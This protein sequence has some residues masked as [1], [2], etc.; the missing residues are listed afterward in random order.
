MT[1]SGGSPEHQARAEAKPRNQRSGMNSRLALVIGFLAALVL[2]GGAY[3]WFYKRYYVTTDN[4][5]V[6]ADSVR[7]SARI[8]GTV[9]AVH[10]L[11][12]QPVQRGQVL[13]E[14]DP[15]DYR[16]AV[17]EARATLEQIE[18]EIR[19]SEITIAVTDVR[20]A[21]N[22]EDAQGEWQQARDK[23]NEARYR[24]ETL[25]SRREAALAE[26]KHARKDAQRYEALYR[27]SA[28]AAR[29][30]DRMHTALKKAEAAFAAVESDIE[31][32][33]AMLAAAREEVQRAQAA[34]TAAR[35]DRERVRL[36]KHRLQALKAR[37]DA[38]AARLEAARLKL[39][40]CTVTA[41]V[42]GYVAQKSVQAGEQIEEGQPLMAIVPLQEVYVEA[43]YKETQ[44][45]HL[46]L[47]QPATIEADT[48]PGITFRGRIA[49][50]RA[51]TGAAFSLLPPENA[52]GNWIKV[53]QRVPVKIYLD[54]PPRPEHPLRL[55]LSLVVTVDTHDRSG[56]RLVGA[57]NTGMER[58]AQRG[59]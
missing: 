51:G 31:A 35:S 47:G 28:A 2:A 29:D 23:V 57:G 34:V 18:A 20:T 42:S 13:L 10:V 5:Y 36:E 48:Y 3:W 25:R 50:I 53:V 40:Y 15:D 24:V 26:L 32:A 4:A 33:G 8:P 38:A 44:L 37:R 52:T 9:R 56:P 22:L 1:P 6:V 14:L 49:G 59:G 30:R 7:I 43:N 17:D 12:D 16:V 41:P 46:H 21:S 45:E 58:A 19:A 55:G 39:S 54:E 27:S 11:N